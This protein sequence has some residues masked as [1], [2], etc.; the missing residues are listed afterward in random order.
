MQQAEVICDLQGFRGNQNEFIVKE[1]SFISVNEDKYQSFVFRP[2]FSFTEL[3]D[4][5]KK[6]A[7]YIER[8]IHGLSWESG[9]I[10]YIELKNVLKQILKDY[11]IVLVKGA[12]KK[13]FLEENTPVDITVTDLEDYN[14]PS[15]KEFKHLS[16]KKCFYHNTNS[17][18]CAYENVRLLLEWYKK[19]HTLKSVRDDTINKIGKLIARMTNNKEKQH[20]NSLECL[21]SSDILYLPNEFI[22]NYVNLQDIDQVFD[23][24]PLKVQEKLMQFVYCFEHYNQPGT[25]HID[26]P[27]PR[28][29]NCKTCTHLKSNII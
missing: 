10:P 7:I 2:P 4:I 1:A 26:G 17:Y 12:E 27:P 29:K 15:M 28:K 5:Q 6:G 21:R 19:V 3:N 18:N 11:K 20:N 9:H 24:S 13:K 25:T 8:H 23:K 14:C 22:R 16:S